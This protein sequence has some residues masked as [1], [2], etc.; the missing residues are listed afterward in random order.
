[1]K[2]GGPR[3]RRGKPGGVTPGRAERARQARRKTRSNDLAAAGLDQLSTRAIVEAIHREDTTVARAVQR[4]LPAIT[5]AVD[6]IVRALAN[7]G[8]LI[9]VGAGTS[10][11]LAVLDAAECPP[12]FGVPAHMVTAVIAGGR[13]ALTSSAE[14]AE[15]SAV[16][17]QRD[18]AAKRLARRDIVVAITA[19]GATPYV[20]GA[21]RFA[22]RI[23]AAT[24]GVTA[25]RRSPVARLAGITIAAQTG[26]E[27]IEGSTRMKAGTAQKMILNLL[28]T[29][30]MVR[31][32]H[33][34]DH[35]MVDVA[36]TNRKLRQRGVRILEEAAGAT[37]ARATSALRQASNNLRVALIMLKTQATAAQAAGR[38]RI[39]RGNL[40]R[41]LGE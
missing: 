10:G 31:L 40:R 13:R 8:R 11:R 24:I 22:R 1:V 38:L 20:L 7:G 9:Y 19:S 23:G 17:G 30:A 2:K 26:A 27:V 5:R 6:A 14:D 33:V 29:T 39:A 16:R 12:T 28:S 32:G 35:W 4:E 21:L 34:Y 25:N 36:L 15:D 18:L 37:A 41:A 3:A